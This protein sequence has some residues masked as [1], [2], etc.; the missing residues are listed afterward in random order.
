M[1]VVL[2]EGEHRSADFDLDPAVLAGLWNM[3][4]RHFWHSARNRWIARAIEQYGPK[5]PARLLEVGCGSGAV[6]GDLQRRGYTVVGID[7]AGVLVRK[8]HERFPH[9]TF[10]VGRVDQLASEIDPFD[11][12][13]FFDVLEHLED[14]DL[15]VRSA[16]THAQPGAL[17]IATVP[18]RRVLFSVVD[19]LSGHKR[20][21]ELGELAAMFSRVGLVD[22]QEHG[23]FRAIQ[24][25]LRSRRA[26]GEAPTDPAERRR[27][28]V[29]ES[30]V[31]PW[32]VNLLLDLLCGA[33]ARIGFGSAAGKI[34]P[35]LLAV[36][37]VP[38]SPL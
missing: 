17:V 34:G 30:R 8:A 37:R 25:L 6:A 35:T 27:I 31:P 29:N 3:E 22:V 33:E 13:G 18:A 28:L 20:R 10:V 24:P 9:A 32:P 4:E 36:G 21:Y 14:P 2:S 15:I 26:A 1:L 11:V 23:I 16:L 19:E 38:P 12:V 7:T 5:P